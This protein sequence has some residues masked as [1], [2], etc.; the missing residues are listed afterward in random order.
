MFKKCKN[1]WIIKF[2]QENT[3]F[4][5][6]KAS[7]ITQILLAE[8]NLTLEEDLTVDSVILLYNYSDFYVDLDD[9]IGVKSFIPLPP[10]EVERL[11]GEDPTNPNY[12]QYQWNSAGMTFENW[13]IAHFRV[14]GNDKY[15]PYAVSYTHLT[16]PTS[17]LV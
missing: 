12:V 4:L 1:K 3:Y 9:K 2:H 8:S 10:Q 11:E 15:A 6:N 7:F 14:L 16:L 5:K 17:D 13:Q